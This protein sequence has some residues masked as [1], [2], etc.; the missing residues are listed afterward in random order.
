MKISLFPN[1]YDE[2]PRSWE[3]SW[4]E[5]AQQFAEHDYSRTVKEQCPAF[6]PAAFPEGA[7]NRLDRLVTEV[8]ALVLDADH[9]REDQ[10]LE[11]TGLIQDLGLAARVY[12]TWSHAEGPWRLRPVIPLSRPVP[13]AAWADFWARA[14]T[15]FGGVCDPKCRNPARIYF[16]PYAPAGTED[17]NFSLLF[18]GEPLDVDAVMAL[19]PWIVA[20]APSA[21]QYALSRDEFERF[22]RALARKRSDEKQ[23]EI[24]EL[25]IKVLNGE[26]FAEPSNRDNVL[27]F[28]LAPVLA[29][30]FFDRTPESI[31]EC[32]RLS[33]DRMAR[34]AEGAPTVEVVARKI[35]KQQENIRLEE[36]RQDNEHR[37]RIREAFKNGRDDPYSLDELAS[38]GPEINKRWII[39]RGGSFYFFVGRVDGG[40][41]SYVGPFT[42]DDM[43]TAALRDLAPASSAGVQL[44]KTQKDGSV[45][46]KTFNQLASQYGTVA[47][48]IVLD[49]KAQR[50][51]YEE[52]TR[53]LHEAP[54]PLR[55]IDPVFHANIDLWL[56]ILAGDKYEHVKTWLAAVT[57]LES[58]CVALFLTGKKSTGKG[59]LANGVARLWT[60][61][62]PTPLDEALS[63]FNDV[64]AR[65]PLCFADEQLPKDFRGY[66][67]NAELRHHIQQTDRPF[68]RKFQPTAFMEGATRTIIAANNENVLSTPEN[69]SAHDIEAIIERYFHVRV[70]SEAADYLKDT[71]T[72]EWVRGDRIAEHVMWLIENH[73]WKPDGRFLMRVEDESL[74]RALAT[75][76]GVRSAVCQW[77][78]GYLL[79]PK[80]FDND[81]RGQGFVRIKEGKLLVNAQGLLN[82]WDHYVPNER[83]PTTGHLASDLSALCENTNGKN[84]QRLRYV[85]KMG[86]RV[87]YRIFN[88]ENL[89]AWAEKSGFADREQIEEALSKPTTEVALSSVQN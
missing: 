51:H 56:Q 12:T 45:I 82:C 60:K 74:H 61:G 88:V 64:I 14:N 75:R 27:F 11:L 36:V 13:G 18:E 34:I 87:N 7:S 16:G 32:F 33:C 21:E 3:G 80:K 19:E 84:D 58:A 66:A 85:N 30:R 62:M 44:F 68:K 8:S 53:T 72:S 57:K 24:G 54:C 48:K 9:L 42:K 23:A 79:N 55:K 4:E 69:L 41:G 15:L 63:D 73:P 86:V 77:L 65:C 83:C 38:F 37:Q 43:F 89:V 71:D 52:Q 50:A 1:A 59:L 22:A 47:E 78:T 2:V 29:Q 25:L 81:A 26:A 5:L 17:K 70:Q 31:A 46:P 39:Q 20:E 28:R 76:T 35:R 40:A 49:L 10:A 67:K 6:S